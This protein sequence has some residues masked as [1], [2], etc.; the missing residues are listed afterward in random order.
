MTRWPVAFTK[1]Y[2]DAG[3]GYE[4]APR[5]CHAPGNTHGAEN[6][7]GWEGW[8]PGRGTFG[9]KRHH[10]FCQTPRG[11]RGDSGRH[12]ADIKHGWV[13][14]SLKQILFSLK[15]HQIVCWEE[16]HGGERPGEALV[17]HAVGPRP[18]P[19]RHHPS[20]VPASRAPSDRG[21]ALSP[22]PGP[23]FRGSPPRV[24]TAFPILNQA[25]SGR[26]QHEAGCAC[27]LGWALVRTAWSRASVGVAM[28][29]VH[30]PGVCHQLAGSE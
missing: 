10:R 21:E 3:P 9:A 29:S 6:E 5:G 7:S 8:G 1:L 14:P 11:A 18:G 27:Q 23:P 15:H 17:L 20:L 25:R 30:V 28:N 12:G 13:R 4:S 19:R 26:S 24:D 2:F 22:G 16:A